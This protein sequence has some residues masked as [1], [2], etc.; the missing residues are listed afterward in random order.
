MLAVTAP[1]KLI[2]TIQLSLFDSLGMKVDLVLRDRHT[3]DIAFV[4]CRVGE[5]KAHT[6]IDDGNKYNGYTQTGIAYPNSG[7]QNSES[8]RDGSTV[9][10]IVGKDTRIDNT[11]L[12]RYELLMI[13]VS[14]EVES[15]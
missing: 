2:I 3:N 7:A 10:F 15:E 6:Y 5:V 4:Y 8:N 12:K 14:E 11:P 9:E 13:I 1:W